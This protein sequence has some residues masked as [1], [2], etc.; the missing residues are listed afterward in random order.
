MV[1]CAATSTRPGS[2]LHHS[3]EYPAPCSPDLGLCFVPGPVAFAVPSAAGPVRASAAVL[4][5]RHVL[6]LQAKPVQHLSG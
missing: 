1:S 4:S 5:P 2:I 3:L 6:S